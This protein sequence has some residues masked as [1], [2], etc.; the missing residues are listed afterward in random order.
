MALEMIQFDEEGVVPAVVQDSATGE[1]LMLAYMNAESLARTL[2]TGETWF[3]SRSEQAL[4]R[5]D[6]EGRQRLVELRLDCDGDAVIVRVEAPGPACHTG[7]RSCF[8][9]PLAGEPPAPA[10]T[11]PMIVGPKVPA[12]TLS[13]VDV[14]SMEFGILLND[15]YTLIH[16]REAERP[17]GSYTARLFNGG[18][19]AILKKVGE[20]AID[21]V[22]AAKSGSRRE[23]VSELSDLLYHVIVL[24]V[25][26][27]IGLKEICQELADRVGRPPDARVAPG[28]RE[29]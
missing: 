14:D 29:G 27:G 1:V 3:W 19:D 17:E 10:R 16:M 11:A 6:T 7:E 4:R 21:A 20:E 15:L 12:P 18:L 26:R 24:M 2:Q 13:L 25:E 8:F 22:I 28:G 23:L 9:R 5:A